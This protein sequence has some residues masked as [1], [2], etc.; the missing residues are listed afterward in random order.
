[1]SEFRNEQQIRFGPFRFDGRVTSAWN[2]IG[3]EGEFRIRGGRALYEDVYRGD[4]SRTD[5]VLLRRLDSV[6][7]GSLRQVNR[8]VGPDQ[9]VEVFAIDG[10]TAE[11]LGWIGRLRWTEDGKPYRGRVS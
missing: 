6:D 5:R 11:R 1:M 2:L 10:D 7:D 8:W 4:G 9:G 3:A